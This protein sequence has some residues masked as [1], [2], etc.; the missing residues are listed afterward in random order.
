MSLTDRMVIMYVIEGFTSSLVFR[1]FYRDKM[2]HRVCIFSPSFTSLVSLQL[3]SEV[4]HFYTDTFDDS[5]TV[6]GLLPFDLRDG[7]S[8]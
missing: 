4:S 7:Q 3:N 8:C 1:C 6:I 5:G 2:V